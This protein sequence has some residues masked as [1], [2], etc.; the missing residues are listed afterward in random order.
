M[1]YIT[2]PITRR[3]IRNIAKWFK[4]ING[5][6][7]DLCFDVVSA[8]ERFPVFF[9]N[10]ITEVVSDNDN[11]FDRL[12]P[13]T[14]IPDMMG[15]YKIL[16]RESVYTDAYNERGGPRSHIVHEMA[17]AILC[18][19]GYTPLFERSFRNREI[20]PCYRSM[21]WQAKALAGE[22][23][24]PYEKTIGMTYLQIQKACKVSKE[25]AQA[26]IRIDEYNKK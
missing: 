4:K 20:R 12:S 10:V 23:M 26:R 9:P 24:V 1:D 19:L 15:N 13:A 17:H 7:D 11:Q 18:M 5:A 3:D 2:K 16:I 14:C 8:F 21:E 25:C 6:Q 22:I